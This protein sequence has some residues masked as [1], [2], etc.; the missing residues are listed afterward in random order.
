[1]TS[2]ISQ[3]LP[4][5]TRSALRTVGGMTIAANEVR[6]LTDAEQ[7]IIIGDLTMED[8]S[9]LI[10]P[11][12]FGQ[13]RAHILRANFGRRVR[14]S[15]RGEEGTTVTDP[16]KKRRNPKGQ[17][18]DVQFEATVGFNARPGKNG[19]SGV[20]IQIRMGLESAIDLII[21]ASGG[22][23]GGSGA[24]GD[25]AR[26]RGASCNNGCGGDRGGRGGAGHQTSGGDGGNIFIDYW[27]IGAPDPLTIG[28]GIGL[29][30]NGGQPGPA[31]APG[32]GGPGGK[33][34]KCAWG[35]YTQ[36]TGPRGYDGIMITGYFGDRGT[37]RYDLADAPMSEVWV[38]ALDD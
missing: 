29:V 12:H 27:L 19:G 7:F 23:G 2:Q 24:A 35:V 17:C 8:D 5:N 3:E 30:S 15:A 33:G 21:D 32:R 31:S 13:W 34:K 37:I 38:S 9:T 36:P 26:G 16:A 11:S 10:V 22:I 28:R 6:T 4:P 14:I 25:G 20:N 18:R 1:M